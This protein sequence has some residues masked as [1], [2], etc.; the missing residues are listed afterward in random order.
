MME[1]NNHRKQH[2]S[3]NLNAVT[4]I[5]KR[6]IIIASAQTIVRK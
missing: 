6:R 5:D 3:T 1:M 2:M 4:N